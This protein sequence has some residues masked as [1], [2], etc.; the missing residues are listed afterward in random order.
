MCPSSD[1]SMTSPPL[2][3]LMMISESPSTIKR[4]KPSSRANR[5]ARR[6]ACTS[7]IST[8]VG[9]GI[10]YD[11]VAITSSSL[12]R[13]IIPSPMMF[14]VGNRAPSKLIFTKPEGGGRHLID[15]EVLGILAWMGLSCWNSWR[16][17]RAKA[18]IF[19][20]LEICFFSSKLK[21]PS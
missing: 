6:A 21:I 18:G 12:L 17:S 16:E 13:T 8:K 5:R 9:S 15:L 19:S 11:R 10:C 14:L 20:L 4:S 1:E 7:T 3:A 2:M